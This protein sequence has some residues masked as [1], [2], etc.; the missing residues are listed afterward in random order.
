[1]ASKN[2]NVTK[3]KTQPQLT[4]AEVQR[5]AGR[6]AQAL[7]SDDKSIGMLTLLFDYIADQTHLVGVANEIDMIKKYL[8]VG[9]SAVEGA[10]KRFESDAYRNCGKL[11]RW[12]NGRKGSA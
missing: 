3:L 7:G 4:H 12:P 2:S 1:M 11:L 9:S 5:L 6:L 8:F 10:Q